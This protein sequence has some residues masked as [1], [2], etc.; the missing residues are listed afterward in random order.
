[1]VLAD[2]EDK[3]QAV[4]RYHETLARHL[5]SPVALTQWVEELDADW[6]TGRFASVGVAEVDAQRHQF[7]ILLA[8]HPHPLLRLPDGGTRV[9]PGC[10]LG[11]VGV[12]LGTAETEPVAR[13]FPM[14]ACLVLVSDGVLDA[15][16]LTRRG[17]FGVDRL[18]EAVDSARFPSQV[19]SRILKAVNQHLC[20]AHPE[21]DMTIVVIARM[22]AAAALEASEVRL[23]A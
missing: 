18:L 3:G 9:L 6:P 8:G 20:G 12:N 23:V 10:R 14:G 5:S 7:R 2:V 16:V 13:P 4:R 22:V 11:L 19:A 1:V 21:D 15:G 17:A